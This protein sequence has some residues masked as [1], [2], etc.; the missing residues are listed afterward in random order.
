MDVPNWMVT[1][2]GKGIWEL[3]PAVDATYHNKLPMTGNAV[4]LGAYVPV[5]HRL[6][7]FEWKHLDENLVDGTDACAAMLNRDDYIPSPPSG[8]LWRL[9]YEAAST[10]STT[11][12]PFGEAYEYK[13]CRYQISFNTTNGDWIVPILYLQ[14]L[15]P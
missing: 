9:Y 10:A 1:Y 13:R 8:V 15:K 2:I 3:R 12:V 5:N 7:K 6:I 4:T 11:I 14:E